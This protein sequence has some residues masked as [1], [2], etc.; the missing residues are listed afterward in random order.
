MK[1][2]NKIMVSCW[3][4]DPMVCIYS[5]WIIFF[6]VAVNPFR[7]LGKI[8]TW[9]K[10]PGGKISIFHLILLLYIAFHLYFISCEGEKNPPVFFLRFHVFKYTWIPAGPFRTGRRLH[11]LVCVYT[12]QN[13]T[14]LKITCQW[15]I[16][17]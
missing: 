15:L 14:L 8:S 10:I 7:F 1:L 13:A 4:G 16:S 3:M 5:S 12:C 11:S 9:K 2:S 6:Q 17:A